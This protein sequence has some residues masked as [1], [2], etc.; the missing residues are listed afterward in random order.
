MRY[1]NCIHCIHS[2]WSLYYN[3]YLWLLNCINKIFYL[4][5]LNMSVKLTNLPVI[6]FLETVSLPFRQCR[7][8]CLVHLF[9]LVIDIYI[10]NKTFAMTQ[11][12]YLLAFEKFLSSWIGV[13]PKYSNCNVLINVSILL[14][15][16]NYF[17][18]NAHD[19]FT[20][21]YIN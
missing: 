18:E 7:S 5:G 3:S 10:I 8:H 2:E 4:I 15:M 21:L 14:D 11:D 1:L 16:F 17:L 6:N 19:L 13:Q 12:F 9:R 20:Y